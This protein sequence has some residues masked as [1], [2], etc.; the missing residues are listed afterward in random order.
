MQGDL[1]RF[2]CQFTGIYAII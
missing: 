1:L 2:A